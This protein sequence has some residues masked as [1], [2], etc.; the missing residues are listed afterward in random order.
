MTG[1]GPASEE[2]GVTVGERITDDLR[3]RI[4]TGD[5]Q[6]GARIVVD[7]LRQ[8]YNA[9]HI[10]IREALRSLGAEGLLVHVPN[11][12]THVANLSLAELND[13]YEVRLLL[14]PVL[15]IRASQ[16]KTQWQIAA[17]S[18]A[19][20]RMRTTDPLAEPL[21]FQRAHRDFHSA[22]VL[23]ACTPTMRRVLDPIWNSVQRYLIVLY[24][25]PYVAPLGGVEHE[26]IFSAWTAGDE[27]CG[28]LL[29]RHLQTAQEELASP[30][31]QTADGDWLASR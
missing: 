26:E 8:H 25:R 3:A 15:V 6:P 4:L 29:C 27:A 21:T 28:Q 10:P 2:R 30:L 5:L 13:M 7:Q 20:E 24:S 14:E 17:A 19:L 12:G 23:P 22:L 31:G 1:D 9:S 16:K 18:D 11:R